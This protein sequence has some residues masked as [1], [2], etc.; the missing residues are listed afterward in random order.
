M[1]SRRT[2]VL[3]IALLAVVVLTTTSVSA[4]QASSTPPTEATTRFIPPIAT[5]DTAIAHRQS[6]PSV[7]LKYLVEQALERNPEIRILQPYG[8]LALSVGNCGVQRQS[9]PSV[10]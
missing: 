3:A 8:R 9:E 5:L 10:G 2:R 6:E 4:Q 1:K 7:G